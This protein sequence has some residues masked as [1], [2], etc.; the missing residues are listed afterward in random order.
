MTVQKPIASQEKI[1]SWHNDLTEIFRLNS[2]GSIGLMDAEMLHRAHLILI[3]VETHAF[4]E[5]EV[6]DK[7]AIG[8]LFRLIWQRVENEIPLPDEDVYDIRARLMELNKRMKEEILRDFTDAR[9]H[10]AR[11]ASPTAGPKLS[12]MIFFIVILLP[13]SLLFLPSVSPLTPE[14]ALKLRP[15]TLKFVLKH[16]MLA[17]QLTLKTKMVKVCLA[18][19]PTPVLL[20]L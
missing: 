4:G 7:R 10:A 15:L 17:H 5:G 1:R 16:I 2:A 11:D 12:C 3:D 9:N 20:L 19:Y 8:F 18:L 14:A 6:A 13:F